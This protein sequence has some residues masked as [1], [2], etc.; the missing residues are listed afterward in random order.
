MHT[1]ADVEKLSAEEIASKSDKVKFS[2]HMTYSVSFK[3]AGTG[4][5]CSHIQAE[6]QQCIQVFELF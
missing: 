1:V 3:V 4:P 2:L 6:R 5:N